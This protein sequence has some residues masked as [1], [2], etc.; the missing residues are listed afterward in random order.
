MQKR[1]GGLPSPVYLTHRQAAA[2]M[3]VGHNTV[4]DL[5]ACG[6]LAGI[7]IGK[8]RTLICVEDIRDLMESAKVRTL[9]SQQ[10]RATRSDA[11]LAAHDA[12]W[13]EKPERCPFSGGG[14]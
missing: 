6:R 13:D 1:Q 8:K 11:R 12:G 3:N 5:L 2:L 4:D 7:R 10:Q 14:R 9:S